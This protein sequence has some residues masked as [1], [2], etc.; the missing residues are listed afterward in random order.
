[1]K[2]RGLGYIV[3]HADPSL[4]VLQDDNGSVLA[5]IHVDDCLFATKAVSQ[6]VPVL[7]TI[8]EF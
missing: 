7:Q 5:L 1:M 8:S 2:L 3:S 6:L 4:F